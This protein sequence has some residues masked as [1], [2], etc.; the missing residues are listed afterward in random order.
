MLAQILKFNKVQMETYPMRK[1]LFLCD[2]ISR[3]CKFIDM[4]F[5]DFL[6]FQWN[7]EAKRIKDEKKHHGTVDESSLEQ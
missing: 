6:T 7:S 5:Q 4:F 3:R 2:I 1:Q